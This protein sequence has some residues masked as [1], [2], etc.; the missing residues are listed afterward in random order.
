MKNLS[1]YSAALWITLSFN[2]NADEDKL[3]HVLVS[4]PLAKQQAET[5]LPITQL[6]ETALSKLNTQTLGSALSSMPGLANA[7]FGPAVGQPV[8]RG[9][10]GPRVS[11]L[12]N[13]V[14]SADASSLSA[15]HA[16]A[17]EPILAEKIEILRGPSTLLYGGG[18]I[19]GVINVIDNRIPTR[20]NAESATKIEY[21]HS[22]AD[23][24]DH[25][26][27]RHDTSINQLA[28]HADLLYRDF[29]ELKLPSGVPA[30]STQ[31]LAL[32]GETIAD[33][34]IEPRL[35][36]TQGRSDSFTAGFSWHSNDG[37][38]GMAVNQLNNLYGIPGHT[39]GDEVESTAEQDH[40]GVVIDLSQTRTDL[41]G[42]WQGL[43]PLTANINLHL[44]HT[45]YHHTE[46]EGV[47]VGTRYENESNELRAQ[48]SHNPIAGW[49]GVVGLQASDIDFAAIGDEAFVPP[50]NSQN[51]GIFWLEDFETANS[52]HEIGLRAEVNSRAPDT[53][54]A[55]HASSQH[56]Q[57]LSASYSYVWNTSNTWQLS[58]A[59][60]HSERAPAAEELYSNV[61]IQDP[62]AWITH[63]ATGAIE[64]GN[65]WLDK[66]S[67][68][69]LELAWRYNNEDWSAEITP[70]YNRFTNYI[71]LV[72]AGVNTAGTPIYQYT[73]DRAHFW[74]VEWRVSR[75]DSSSLGDISATLA[76]DT[77]RGDM[78]DLGSMPRLPPRKLVA[79]LTWEYA[80]WQASVD[81]LH[82]ST[83]HR[84]G[85]GELPSGAYDKLDLQLQ[86]QVDWQDSTI[87]LF[88]KIDNALD[89]EIRLSTSFLRDVAPAAGRSIDIG[90]RAEF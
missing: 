66:E 35:H 34:M 50:T 43:S 83:Q 80:Q 33:I 23:N 55:Q 21:R 87:T 71:G 5:A 15:D 25:L 45:N 79:T 65:P 31:L 49:V 68:N 26:I 59:L 17:V 69:N 1:L 28:L 90:I 72:H 86:Y 2:V 46:L 10:Q 62:N 73:Q 11:V 22:S 77:T 89:E 13:G 60:S 61:F 36:N 6:E 54:I 40:E 32:E 58:F 48:W 27:A 74:G 9:Q 18:A 82:A 37:Y 51:V 7:S 14:S 4:V 56:F 29:G 3:E 12:S 70:Y 41:F 85:A 44:V 75:Y 19:G 57:A 38:W 42:S 47:A 78:A 52:M 20:L 64:V 24:G 53:A 81:W 76:G 63:A 16:V 30:E 39:H 67:T 88:G 84:P 8:I